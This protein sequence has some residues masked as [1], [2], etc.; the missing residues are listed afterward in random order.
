ML[1]NLSDVQINYANNTAQSFN[2]DSQKPDAA[3]MLPRLDVD[4]QIPWKKVPLKVGSASPPKSKSKTNPKKQLQ[5]D[6]WNPSIKFGQGQFIE[7][8]SL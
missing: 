6:D 7:D 5:A 1:W 8:Q 3:D 2:L 4:K